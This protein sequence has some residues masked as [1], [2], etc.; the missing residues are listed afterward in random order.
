MK[1]DRVRFVFNESARD[2]RNDNVYDDDREDR[3]AD[4]KAHVDTPLDAVK[5]HR[6]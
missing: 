2:G 5:L 3:G 4:D 1:R 6:R